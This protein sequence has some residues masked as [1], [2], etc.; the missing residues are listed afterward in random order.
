MQPWI[1]PKPKLLNTALAPGRWQ[2]NRG[3]EVPYGWGCFVSGQST[4]AIQSLDITSGTYVQRKITC[5]SSGSLFL[6]YKG[7]E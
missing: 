7:G 1:D 2:E 6:L 4:A 5:R 3:I